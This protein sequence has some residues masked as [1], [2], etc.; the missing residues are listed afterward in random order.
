MENGHDRHRRSFVKRGAYA[1]PA[2]LT[3]MAAPDF[4]KAG[5]IKPPA[6]PP[7]GKPDKP[8]KPP[9]KPRN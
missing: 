5:S 9:G 1:A 2:I 4:A 7:G 6:G 3:L 8:G